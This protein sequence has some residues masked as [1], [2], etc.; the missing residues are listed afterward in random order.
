MSIK[1]NTELLTDPIKMQTFRLQN[2][3]IEEQKNKWKMTLISF[4]LGII[5][6]LGTVLLTNM[7]SETEKPLNGELLLNT[8][9]KQA[10]TI[11][12]LTIENTNLKLTLKNAES[13][14]E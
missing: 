5:T 6:A 14:S 11:R 8:V 1:A 9:T 2:L 13:S 12:T 10:E 3:L 4:I 7:L